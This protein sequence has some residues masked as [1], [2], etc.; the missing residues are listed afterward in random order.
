MI[1][2]CWVSLQVDF[3][4]EETAEMK[5][6]PIGWFLFVL[7]LGAMVVSAVSFAYFTIGKGDNLMLALACALGLFLSLYLSFIKIPNWFCEATTRAKNN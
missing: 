2:A 1:P 3:L 6:S 4:I 5:K 7:S